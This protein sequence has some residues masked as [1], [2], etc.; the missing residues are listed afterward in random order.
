VPDL[1]REM[2]HDRSIT[3]PFS[4]SLPAD[5]QGEFFI[6]T[7][8][9]L[10]EL[11]ER[12]TRAFPQ[13]LFESCASGGGRFDPG[14]MPFAPQAWASDDTDAIER[15]RIQWG[16]SLCYPSAPWRP[17]SRLYRTTRRPADATCDPGRGGFFGVLGY[18]L[19][20][21]ALSDEDRNAV[22]GQIAFYKA[23]RDVLQRGRLVR[24]RSP[25]EGD[26]TKRPG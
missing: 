18:E 6:A 26:G 16:T 21:A 22:K 25:F 9:V 23:H 12:L 24:L 19:D 5:R 1:A 11:Y 2:G 7:S 13:V 3:E 14:M 17:T 15:L 8:W 4:P 20:P 10:Y